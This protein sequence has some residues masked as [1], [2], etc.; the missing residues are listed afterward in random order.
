MMTN[1][2]KGTAPSKAIGAEQIAP[3]TTAKAITHK[4]YTLDGKSPYSGK[5]TANRPHFAAYTIAGMAVAGLVKLNKASVTASKGGN[6]T[7]LR[8]VIGKVATG[9]WRKAGRI[10]DNGITV[11]GLNEIAARLAGKSRGY[12]TDMETVRAMHKAMTQGG[13]HT[14]GKQRYDFTVEVAST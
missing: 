6:L 9:H 3:Q 10:D 13:R 2:K 14:I 11:A 4:G 5:L 1:I 7:F 12:N 8:M